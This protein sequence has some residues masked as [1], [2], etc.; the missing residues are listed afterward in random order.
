VSVGLALLPSRVLSVHTPR[1]RVSPSPGPSVLASCF[2]ERRRHFSH[3]ATPHACV[4]K[5]ACRFLTGE[6]YAGVY[7][8]LLAAE[9]LAG[10]AGA[11]QGDPLNLRGMAIGDA[12]AGTDVMCSVDMDSIGM[13]WGALG[14][15]GVSSGDLSVLS[16]RHRGIVAFKTDPATFLLLK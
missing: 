8:P 1:G 12:C 3:V 15:W 14:P 2:L 5:L 16:N 7:L 11:K 13:S 10:N 9:V 4:N 6:S